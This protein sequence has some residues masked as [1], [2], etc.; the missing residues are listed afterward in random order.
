MKQ[1]PTEAS[2]PREIIGGKTE[3]LSSRKSAEK[4]AVELLG[5]GREESSKLSYNLA[6]LG[7][8]RSAGWVRGWAEVQDLRRAGHLGTATVPDA[9]VHWV[10]GPVCGDGA[11]GTGLD[12]L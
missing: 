1:V 9:P 12:H 7:K 6:F 10:C 8:V 2:D 11:P 4:L 5:H 3:S